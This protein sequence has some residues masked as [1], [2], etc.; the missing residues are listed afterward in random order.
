MVTRI[1]SEGF[2]IDANGDMAAGRSDR[3]GISG[4]QIFESRPH[5][6][7][8]NDGSRPDRKDPRSA[9]DGSNAQLGVAR[10]QNSSLDYLTALGARA[11]RNSAKEPYARDAVD[12]HCTERMLRPGCVNHSDASRATSSR[13]PGSGNK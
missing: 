10:Q 9:V 1:L 3:N 7:Q 11:K 4:P 5:A 13:A 6:V 12:C 2:G 8:S